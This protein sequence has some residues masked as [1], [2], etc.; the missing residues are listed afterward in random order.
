MKK[1]VSLVSALVLLAAPAVSLA[2]INTLNSLNATGQFLATTTATTTMHMKIVSATNTHTFQ[3]DNTPWRVDQ[4]GTGATAFS[5]GSVLFYSSGFVENNSKFYWDTTNNALRI[6]T[7]TASV[8]SKLSIAGSVG[9]ALLDVIST[10]GSHLL[11]IAENGNIGVG[12]IS[13]QH[14]LDIVGAFYSRLVNL[15][16]ASSLTINW[17]SGN[18]QSLTL[19]TNTTLTFSNGAAGGEYKLIVNH[20]GVG[21]R[22]IT[23]PGSVKW[24]GGVAPTLTSSASS[25]DV[26]SFL[27]DGTNYLGSAITNYTNGPTS[28]T[29]QALVV[30]GGGGGA[31]GG[32]GGGAGGL[33]YNA[34]STVTPQAYSITVGNGGAGGSS[35]SRV[36]FN[37]SNSAFSTNVAIGGGG[38]GTDNG[39]G[40]SGG[41]GGGGEYNVPGLGGAG[42]FGQGH[43]GGHGDVVASGGYALAG[44]GGG[45]NVAGVN[46]DA[47]AESSG[48]G[49]AGLSYAISGSSVTYAGGGGGGVDTRAAGTPG[50]GGIGG[51]GNGS[52]SSTGDNG[53][54]N[55]GGGRGGGEYAPGLDG[56]SGGSGVVIISYPTG[57]IMATGGTITTS[58]GNTIHTFTSSGTFTVTSIN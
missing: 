23:W 8:P 32:G 43:D 51:G 41:S 30:A 21:G 37:G 3:W 44:G 33:I 22:T 49:G 50:N 2:N 39:S 20:D 6:G 9:Q 29:V 19:T 15:A 38:G 57:S 11:Y 31:W 36:G 55:T 53:T 14:A 7:S 27:Y 52:K 1:L 47:V 16:D 4:G 46:S 34:S 42:T 48:D 58:G 25:T 54:A 12:T 45:A 18:V 24:A 10:V 26:M 5:N 56:G 35:G 40:S 13:P 28:A 17:N